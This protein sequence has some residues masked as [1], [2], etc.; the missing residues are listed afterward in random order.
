MLEALCWA[1][2][3]GKA[4]CEVQPSLRLSERKAARIRP[5]DGVA[6]CLEHG[7]ALPWKG[8]CSL[9][10]F[11]L[12]TC[13]SIT[14]E[15]QSCSL[16]ASF[17]SVSM[18]HWAR[19]VYEQLFYH[20][21]CRNQLDKYLRFTSLQSASEKPDQEQASTLENPLPVSAEHPF[22]CWE[23]LGQMQKAPR[24]WQSCSG[25]MSPGWWVRGAGLSPWQVACPWV[26]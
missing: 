14:G 25:T 15:P 18:S 19:R 16:T 23:R 7:I 8:T 6:A 4:R 9:S 17:C 5:S 20:F 3:T 26:T 13:H 2:G 24:S 10:I 21:H 11:L 22:P 12:Q 1:S